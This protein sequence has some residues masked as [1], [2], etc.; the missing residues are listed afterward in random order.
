MR[1][2]KMPP[3]F[4]LIQKLKED[5]VLVHAHYQAH[6]ELLHD[7][8]TRSIYESL[9][10]V[11]TPD[12]LDR[13]LDAIAKT[14]LSLGNG[15][16]S[17]KGL[18]I[19]VTWENA[20]GQYEQLLKRLTNAQRIAFVK[21][22][23]E[24][25]KGGYENYFNKDILKLASDA[26]KVKE[27]HPDDIIILYD[28]ID[29]LLAIGED[30]DKLFER[31]GWQTAT[32]EVGGT[33]MSVMPISEDVLRIGG[34][35]DFRLSETMVDMINIHVTDPLEAE[36]S[37][38]QQT[39]DAFRRGLPDGNLVFPV[40]DIKYNAVRSGIEH[41]YHYPFVEKSGDTLSLFRS[42]AVRESVVMGQSW[43][44]S[45]DRI[46]MLTS[47]A[48][49]FHILMHDMERRERLIGM[50]ALTNNDIRSLLSY[51]DYQL[52]KK[53]NPQKR[54]LM[55]QGSFFEAYQADAVSLA[56][57]FHHSLWSRDCGIHGEVPMLVLSPMKVGYVL[58]LCDDVVVVKPRIH[59]RMGKM[60]LRPSHLNDC[61]QME[62]V[63]Q[64][65]GIFVKKDGHY[66]VRASL[67]GSQLPMREISKEM[68]D[69]YMNM[70]DGLAKKVYLNGILHTAYDGMLRQDNPLT[71]HI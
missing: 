57:E 7:P 48:E 3:N 39:I 18:P 50:G 26:A 34:L 28:L 66:A 45:L 71:L 21:E 51:E 20:L 70:S 22:L 10:A 37:L 8:A 2:E 15:E 61:L 53:R 33:R 49:C 38:A 12:D 16:T 30:A 67:D 64:D 6:P 29:N 46:P 62:E 69:R 13:W 44:V 35:F 14:D 11:K 23:W 41:A 63:F 4:Y 55:D 36:L 19:G 47:L 9:M 17:Q 24:I 58:D 40:K 54:V 68:G 60:Y 42:D 1:I 5:Y 31:F 32:A 27:D 25:R 65:P 52:H 59:D 43:N 56:R